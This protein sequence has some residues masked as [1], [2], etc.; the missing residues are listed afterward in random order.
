[1]ADEPIKVST[2]QQAAIALSGC[3]AMDVLRKRGKG[4]RRAEECATGL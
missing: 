3:P 2:T 1:L 4:Y